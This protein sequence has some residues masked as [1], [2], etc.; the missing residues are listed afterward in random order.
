MGQARTAL[1][2][3]WPEY[4]IE[5]AGLG[6]FMLM[7][8]ICV[9]LVNAP[10]AI[11]IIG[12]A[13]IRRALVGVAM[14]LTAIAISLALL[15]YPAYL[16]VQAYELPWISDVTTDVNDPPRYDALAKARAAFERVNGVLDVVPDAVVD[17]TLASWVEGQLEAR[18]AARA[19]RDFATADR[20][21]TELEERDVMIEDTPSG[22]K[23]RVAR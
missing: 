14:G 9:M 13:D 6:L 10:D 12:N 17:S 22:T 21:R 16:G 11:R 1:S 19:R 20:I 7:A 23:W 3:H 18:K 4:L 8:G 5:A 15:G 2:S